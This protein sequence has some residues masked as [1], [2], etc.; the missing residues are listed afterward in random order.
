MTP[1]S[2]F[3]TRPTGSESFGS[4]TEPDRIVHEIMQGLFDGRFEPGQ[5]LREAELTGTFG[6]SRGPI[7]EALH[8]LA[9]TGI[10]EMSRKR[11]AQIRIHTIDE[12][13]DV[14]Q[15]VEGLARMAVRL[16]AERIDRPGA[17]TELESA[18]ARLESTARQAS[19][20]MLDI[21]TDALFAKI[22]EIS[23]NS[24]LVRILPTVRTHIINLQFRAALRP[25]DGRVRS[26]YRKIAQAILDGKA[27]AAE[28]AVKLHMSKGIEALEN[29]RST[30]TSD[31]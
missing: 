29:Y 28:S 20:K 30:F 19:R 26:D 23:G 9:A 11:G 4:S 14:M 1:R 5:R 7:R 22:Y 27:A 13:I 25:L 15:V 8:R 3:A 24:E 10:V 18:L 16:A 6:L 17:R 12:A 21:A 31:A 2:M